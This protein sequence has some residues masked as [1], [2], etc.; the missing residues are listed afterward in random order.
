MIRE[1]LQQWLKDNIA[2]LGGKV[3][4]GY[5]PEAA[6][7]PYAILDKGGEGFYV[8]GTDGCGSYWESVLIRIWSDD[9]PTA[10]SIQDSI[11]VALQG[12][13]GDMGGTRVLDVTREDA[14]TDETEEDVPNRQTEIYVDEAVYN[15]Y[16]EVPEPVT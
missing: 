2:S 10:S 12:F 8:A 7:R 1:Q 9:Y 15:I 14:E 3:F 16:H 13:S 6:K 4:Q 5:A 11:R